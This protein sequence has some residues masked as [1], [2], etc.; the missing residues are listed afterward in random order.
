MQHLVLP[1]RCV[2]FIGSEAELDDYIREEGLQDIRK[3]LRQLLRYDG[4]DSLNNPRMER[5]SADMHQLLED[6]GWLLHETLNEA[7]PLVG[8]RR[9]KWTTF[10]ADLARLALIQEPLPEAPPS[11]FSAL[12]CGSKSWNGWRLASKKEAASLAAAAI[13]MGDEASLVGL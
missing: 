2:R 1:E 7:L 12:V 8:S 10:K 5:G 13:A 9:Q 4:V 3:N 6:I 11:I